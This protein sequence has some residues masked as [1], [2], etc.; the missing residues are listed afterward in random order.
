MPCEHGE[1]GS[2]VDIPARFR[3]DPERGVDVASTLAVRSRAV[4]DVAESGG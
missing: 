1:D 4:S 2:E 3:S